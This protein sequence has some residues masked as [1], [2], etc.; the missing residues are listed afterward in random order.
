M[1]YA[2]SRL[3]LGGLALSALLWQAPRTALAQP[4]RDRPPPKG[5]EALETL[6]G[7]PAG[8]NYNP[9]GVY[10]SLMLATDVGLVQLNFPAEL[11]EKVVA[12]TVAGS[13]LAAQVRPER[14]EG[15]HRVYRL[16]KLSAGGQ[17]LVVAGEA[18]PE[19]EIK[20]VVKSLNYG[21]HGETNG[22]VLENGDFVQLGPKEAARVRLEAGQELTARGRARA[23]PNGKQLLKA[24]MINGVSVKPDPGPKGPGG[25]GGTGGPKGGG[26]K[27]RG[28]R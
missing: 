3:A 17:E 18:A 23:L 15:Q 8:F 5:R 22:F 1:N 27:G 10:D 24:N 16:E 26:P 19:A 25:P 9:G 20:G 7:A 11:S 4:T 21:R 28:P 6:A 12:L 14:S 13:A 2:R